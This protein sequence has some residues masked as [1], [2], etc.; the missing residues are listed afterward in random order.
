MSSRKIEGDLSGTVFVTS[1]GYRLT[2]DG[3]AWTDGDLAFE[4]DELS[5]PLRST[6][7]WHFEGTD[8]GGCGDGC[9]RCSGC[10]SI[11]GENGTL[12]VEEL[13]AGE[14]EGSHDCDA[15]NARCE[16]LE[17]VQGDGPAKRQPS[18]ATRGAGETCDPTPKG[19]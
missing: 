18:G 11:W 14:C 2:W 16:G 4:G 10:G 1:D 19:V 9:H 17:P 13:A 15:C 7:R 5:G 3:K 8:S 12:E 6:F